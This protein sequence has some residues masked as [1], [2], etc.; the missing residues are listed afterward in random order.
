LEQRESPA[1]TERERT[2]RRRARLALVAR[3]VAWL[4]VIL[5]TTGIGTTSLLERVTGSREHNLMEDVVI[6]AGFGAVAVVGALLVAKRPSNLVGWILAAV[7]LMVGLF[8]TGEAYA[9]YV[10]T[11][12]GRPDAF[13]VLGAWVQNWYWFLLLGLLLVYLPLLFPDGRLLSRRWLPVAVVP[14]VGLL[15]LVALGMLA[16]NLSGQ[17]VKYRIENPIGIEGPAPVDELPTFGVL[18]GFFFVV[19]T[20]GA[21]AAV[22]VRFR[23]S[24][25]VERQQMKWFLFAV[26]PV[27]TIPLED[28]VPEFVN[29]IASEWVLIGL[30]TAIGV[31]VLRYCLYDIDVIIN[32]TLVYVVL[33]VSLVSIYLGGAAALQYAL[34]A[35]TGQEQQPQL[36]VV[37]STLMI[38][39][40]FN[41]LRRRVQAFVD[42]SFYRKKYDLQK[43]LAG[44]GARLRDETA[45]GRVGENL[46]G[47]N[48]ETLQPEHASLWLMGP[49]S[50]DAEARP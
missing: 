47:V 34:R 38:A 22:V 43:T 18:G 13:V 23:R 25:G 37:A 28:Y 24:R 21:V 35:L 9:A 36:A 32:R 15:G 31:T 14:G 20:L 5:Y 33:T 44:F 17:D 8:P 45:V 48:Q 11:T 1:G 50:G 29:Q 39:A 40:L 19:G 27:L 41:P 12:R 30:P 10:M 26:A 49:G 46:V 7:G 42:R 4:T 2:G 6:L 3:A 16:D